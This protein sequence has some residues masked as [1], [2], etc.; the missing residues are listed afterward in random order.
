MP[1]MDI[2]LPDPP[3]PAG[4]YIP[5][6]RVGNFVY[7]SGQIPFV[8]GTIKYTGK[9]GKDLTVHQGYQAA[10]ICGLNALGVL[11]NEIGD[12][13]LVR[14]IV[15][16]CGYVNSTE[17]FADHPKVVNGASDLMSE[18]F[19]DNGRHSRIAVGANSLP[20][21]SAV[22]IDLIAEVSE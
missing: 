3:N 12:L 11:K 2:R 19:G 16:L 22:E 5:A 15:K 18:V 9:L 7:L 4:S 21:G 17:N 13:H 8:E 6:V 10:R 1:Q 14:R 20:L